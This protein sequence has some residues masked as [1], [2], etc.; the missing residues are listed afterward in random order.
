[1]LSARAQSLQNG[2]PDTVYLHGAWAGGSGGAI[3]SAALPSA[4]GGSLAGV[5]DQSFF[6]SI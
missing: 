3:K 2:L 6:A 4:S 1:M 5:L